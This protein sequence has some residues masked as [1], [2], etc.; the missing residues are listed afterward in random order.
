M[1][2]VC[3]DPEA[4]VRAANVRATLAAFRL[5]PS[6]GRKLVERNKLSLE[7]LRPDNY[8]PLQR[9]LNALKEIHETVGSNLVHRVGMAI[10]ENAHFPPDLPTVEAAL[11]TLDRIYYLNHRGEV[12]HYHT[13]RRPDGAV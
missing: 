3:P 12:G 6:T 5:I 8:V 9:W 13:T 11:E 7:D 10:V 2:F 1:E 4:T